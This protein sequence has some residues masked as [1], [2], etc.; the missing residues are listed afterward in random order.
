VPRFV[1]VIVLTCL[2]VC[3]GALA[4]P[5][6]NGALAQ[7]ASLAGAWNGVWEAD[8][9]RY[10]AVM[11]LNADGAGNLDG[12]IN[13]TLRVS[14]RANEQAKI[15]MKGVEYVRGKYYSDSATIVLEGYRKD[16]PNGIVGLDKYRL[17]LSPTAQTIGGLTEHH[18]SWTGKLFLTH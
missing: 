18:G 6:G 7:P 8:N 10:E 3:I 9:F 16:D 11:T 12:S 15:G 14:P 13:W 2:T 4:A 1:R 5:L 17:V